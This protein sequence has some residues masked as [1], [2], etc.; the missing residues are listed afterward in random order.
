MFCYLLKQMNRILFVTLCLFCSFA[1]AQE[2]EPNNQPNQANP[3][4]FGK[5]VKGIVHAHDGHDYFTLTAPGPGAI[6]VTLSNAP[7]TCRFQV[8]ALGFQQYTTSS[9]GWE[10]SAAGK[11]LQWTFPSKGNFAGYVWVQLAGILSSASQGDNIFVLCRKEGPWHIKPQPNRPLGALPKTF[12]GLPLAEPIEYTLV[13]TFVPEGG[14]APP[15]TA[16]QPVA[17]TIEPF[18][19]ERVAMEKGD[20]KALAAIRVRYALALA[21]EADRTKDHAMFARALLC[22]EGACAALPQDP[23]L[24]MTAARL[25]MRLPNDLMSLSLAEEHLRKAATLEARLLLAQNL[26]YQ[27]RFSAAA[28]EFHAVLDK[29]PSLLK[30]TVAAMLGNCYVL[31]QAPQKGETVFRALLQR[32]PGSPTARAV[33]ALLLYQQGKLNDALALVRQL[34]ADKQAPAD[35]RAYAAKLADAWQKEARR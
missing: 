9:I 31:D 28:A 14:V 18:P 27:R 4:E 6:T 23:Q 2:K 32:Q 20:A 17:E 24:R 22:A 34:S 15:P 13:V 19:D 35:W 10:D 30:P 5:P 7:A 25:Y 12:E 8:G 33:L 11:P 1:V 29:Q 3:I 26:F 16:P 21:E